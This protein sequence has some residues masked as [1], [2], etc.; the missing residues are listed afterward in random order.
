MTRFQTLSSL[1]SLKVRFD[2]GA[3]G[4]ENLAEAKKTRKL[5]E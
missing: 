1:P 2:D 4:L 5:V 3:E